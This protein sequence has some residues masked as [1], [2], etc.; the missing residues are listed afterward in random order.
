MSPV[1]QIY[2]SLDKVITPEIAKRLKILLVQGC[3]SNGIKIVKG[4]LDYDHVHLLLSCP[5]DISPAKIAQLLKGR[6]SRLLQD[7][8]PGLKKRYWGQHLWGR[9]YFCATVGAMTDEMIQEYIEHHMEAEDNI[10]LP[11]EFQ[12]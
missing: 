8:F 11:G 4:H 1:G 6:S 10:S 12:S 5:P 7:E 3:N 9:G 2:L